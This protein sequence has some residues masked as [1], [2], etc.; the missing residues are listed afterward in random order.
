MSEKYETRDRDTTGTQ[1]I[2]AQETPQSSA[3]PQD[4]LCMEIHNHRCFT[5][6]NSVLKVGSILDI[7]GGCAHSGG[8]YRPG[9]VGCYCQVTRTALRGPEGDGCPTTLRGLPGDDGG[10]EPPQE[11]SLSHL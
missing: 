9:L 5:V 1:Q 8:V 10:Q 11:K 3:D 4:S 7:K 2:P 6:D